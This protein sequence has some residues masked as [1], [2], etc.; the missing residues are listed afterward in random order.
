M[1]VGQSVNPAPYCSADNWQT[2]L[3][4][5]VTRIDL[6]SFTNSTSVTNF[7]GYQYNNN[8]PPIN[9]I[10][11]TTN[12]VSLYTQGL[13]IHY[14]GVF[15][16]FNQDIDFDDPGELI[17]YQSTPNIISPASGTFT[18]PSNASA[19]MTRMRVIAFEDDAYTLSPLGQ[20][21]YPY[22]CYTVVAG[23][24]QMGEAEDYDI[25]IT[26][27]LGINSINSSNQ[28]DI[29]KTVPN[30]CNEY[31]SID[32]NKLIPNS[33]QK[34]LRVEVYNIIGDKVFESSNIKQ[35]DL[36]HTAGWSPGIFTVF[37]YTDEGVLL[38]TVKLVKEAN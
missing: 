19:G 37:V 34:G 14:C 16:D 10:A 7:F 27:P 15:I 3:I 1:L 26:S 2:A 21:L 25:F 30:P 35:N 23:Q 32:W 31:F 22:S 17:I 33:S 24:W 4:N 12:T 9:L 13:N 8:L 11:G 28:N 36:I 5:F 18:V 29:I 6:N 20:P 38:N